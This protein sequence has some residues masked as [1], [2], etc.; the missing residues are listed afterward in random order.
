[1][2]SWCQKTIQRKD[3]EMIIVCASSA[4]L[5]LCAFALKTKEGDMLTTERL[6][7]RPLTSADI[8]ALLDLMRRNRTFLEPWSP[9]SDDS[10]YS[11]AALQSE[12]ARRQEEWAQDRA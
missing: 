1:M 11:E 5:H 9:R 10:Q 7:I 4:P 8:P 6:L 2:V 3:A 12:I